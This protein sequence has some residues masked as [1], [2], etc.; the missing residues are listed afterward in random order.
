MGRLSM[1]SRVTRGAAAALVTFALGAPVSGAGAQG[2]APA[3]ARG[4][5][6]VFRAFITAKQ[7][8]IGSL[9]RALER[10]RYG[11]P[12]WLEISG[13]LDSLVMASAGPNGVFFRRAGGPSVARF[14]EPP[15]RG[16]IGINA[17]GPNRQII[18]ETGDRI[19]YLAYPSV[20]SVDPD[21][22]ADRAGIAPGD[23][24]V[25]FNGLDVVGR[26]FDLTK[27]FV[28]EK[29]LGVTIRRDG[30]TKEFSLDIVRAPQRIASRRI[31]L[32]KIPGSPL[33]GVMRID[34]DKPDAPEPPPRVRVRTGEA[35]VT[36]PR[37]AV[38][39]MLMAG[40]FNIITPH[41][42][43][44][45]NVSPVGADLAQVLKLER[46]VLVN[47]VPEESP[48]YKSGLRAGDVIVSASGQPVTTLGQLQDQ[49]LSRLGDRS[50]VLQVMR[51]HKPA[52]LTVTW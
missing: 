45:A 8:T 5:T 12:A 27:L 40:R 49:I 39:A 26:E 47:E 4:D 51:T 14:P 20:L 32:A 17:Q 29:K 9:V 30:E 3:R 21:S 23:L 19:T 52:R 44:G 7:D 36:L 48:A 35:G 22:P 24:L 13:K 15:L 18:D 43:W 10:E 2:V 41:G 50:I 46:G 25:A 1:D 28:P 6:A 34:V 38:P 37:N 33:V 31:E 42:V 16:W 11:S